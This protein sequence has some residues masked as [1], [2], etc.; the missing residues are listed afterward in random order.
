MKRY[1]WFP[2][3]ALLLM[4]AVDPAFARRRV[5]VRERP[6]R[7]VV[8]V[9]RGFPL[10]RRFPVVAVRPVRRTVIVTPLVFR[11]VVVWT[12]AVVTLPA[13]EGL[14]WEDSE[15]L[16]REDEWTEFT[17]VAEARG[18]AL[19]LELVGKAQVNFTEVVFENGDTQVLDF[20]EKTHGTGVY[21]LLDFRDGRKVSHVRMV[22]RAKS[23]TAKIILRMAK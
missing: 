17:L 22:A 6:R 21:R 7:T 16:A 8:V 15:S 18:T 3:F 4:N 23:D 9:H 19:Y 10:H 12:A 20:N 2:I 5:V 1:L 14:V 13:R 11:P